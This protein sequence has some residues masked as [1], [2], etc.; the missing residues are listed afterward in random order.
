MTDIE[1]VSKL[2][3]SEVS[4]PRRFSCLCQTLNMSIGFYIGF[5]ERWWAIALLPISIIVPLWI[6]D[7]FYA[8]EMPDTEKYGPREG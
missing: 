5:F 1:S 4:R 6:W 7:K 3:G 8:R 2:H